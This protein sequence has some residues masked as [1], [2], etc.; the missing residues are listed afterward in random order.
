MER[1]CIKTAHEHV[2]PMP[3]LK[4]KTPV[5]DLGQNKESKKQNEPKQKQLCGS[6]GE[7]CFFPDRER[8][9]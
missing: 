6:K 1:H 7:D 2:S 9:W 5:G 8:L 4:K 3:F